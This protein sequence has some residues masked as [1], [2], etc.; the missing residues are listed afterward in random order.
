MPRLASSGG[1]VRTRSTWQAIFAGAVFVFSAGSG[2]EVSAQDRA[3]AVAAESEEQAAFA[4]TLAET[5]DHP[6]LVLPRRSAE[7]EGSVD[8]W[9]LSAT[10]ED[11]FRVYRAT[12][13]DR[14]HTARVALSSPRQV[15]FN[16]ATS[17]FEHLAQNL[18]VEL[19]DPQALDR[20]VEAAGGTGGK[21]Y[22]LLGFALV[23][24]PAG[25]DPVGALRSVRELPVVVS[26]RLTVRGP[27]R[28]P[29]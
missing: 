5:V 9:R 2:A 21:A 6:L 16:P 24:L 15:A 7:G 20:V 19:R 29:R 28:E 26:A 22:P 25:A 23:H 14:I 18:R 13:G 1:H 10:V 4:I 3:E 8:G 11:G 12:R 17:R 27:K